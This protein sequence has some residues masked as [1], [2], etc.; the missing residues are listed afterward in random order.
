MR[1]SCAPTTVPTRYLARGERSARLMDWRVTRPTWP[2]V[3]R[4]PCPAPGQRGGSRSGSSSLGGVSYSGYGNAELRRHAPGGNASGGADRGR[5]LSSTCPPRYPGPSPGPPPT[6]T[7]LKRAMG[8]TPR[9]ATGRRVRAR[10]SPSNNL[11]GDRIG[12]HGGCPLRHRHRSA[13][14]HPPLRR[15]G[16]VPCPVRSPEAIAVV[17]PA[18]PTPSLLARTPCRQEPPASRPSPSDSRTSQRTG[19]TSTLPIAAAPPTSTRSATEASAPHSYDTALKS[20]RSRAYRSSLASS[21]TT[22]PTRGS[23]LL[24]AARHIHP[25]RRVPPCR[26]LLRELRAQGEIEPPPRAST[27]VP[28]TD[29]SCPSSTVCRARPPSDAR[30]SCA[31][32]EAPCSRSRSHRVPP[33]PSGER[34]SAALGL[35]VGN[36][37]RR[38][39]GD[40]SL[41]A[42]VSPG[43][44]GAR[45]R[46]RP[47]HPQ[48]CRDR[49]GSRLSAPRS[50]RRASCGRPRA[51][52]A[53]G[54]HELALDPRPRPPG[55]LV[56]HAPHDRPARRRHHRARRPAP[57]LDRASAGRPSSACSAS[58]RRSSAARTVPGEPMELRILADAPALTL[59]FLRVGAETRPSERAQRRDARARPRATRCR[60]TGPGSARPRS[61]ITVQTGDWPTGVYAAR[62]TT[63]DG[64]VGF[65]P[66]VLR[67][68]T[69]GAQRQ[70]VVLPTNTWQAYNIYDGDGDGWG[71]TWYAGGNPPVDLTRPYRDRGVPPRFKALRPRLPAL[72]RTNRQGRP[73]SSPTTTSRRSRPATSCARATTS[74]VFPGHSEYVT[75]ARLRRR[76]SATATSAA[77]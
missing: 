3:A 67:P 14:R 13:R 75:G 49:R 23:R 71:D 19:S 65:A 76:S 55:R 31:P 40:R 41:F 43:D 69:P 51:R 46:N 27:L 28:V 6:R 53:P 18:D 62:L 60:W 57:G 21:H 52:F 59:Q 56:R 12:D 1:H 37:G 74:I 61:T 26:Q 29:R 50:A 10:R 70:L 7:K 11:P 72:A 8:G 66:F 63:D 15:R 22:P 30:A 33:S 68:T 58:R 77:G 36:I 39:A 44:P 73:T 24:G 17:S 20:T 47:F 64:R 54:A 45:H 4:V 2:Q 32:Q 25:G 34:A 16:Q 42:T 5:Q 9:S 38:Y 48:S 35:T